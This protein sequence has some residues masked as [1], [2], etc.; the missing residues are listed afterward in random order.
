MERQCSNPSNGNGD[1]NT[2][3]LDA[4]RQG[5]HVAGPTGGPSEVGIFASP[6]Q[7]HPDDFLV[8]FI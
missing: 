4:A 5:P 6:S 8:Q 3:L 7:S 2:H 1:R